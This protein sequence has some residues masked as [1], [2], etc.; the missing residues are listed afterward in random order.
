VIGNGAGG[1]TTLARAL[2][3][4]HHE[5][6]AVVFRSDWS[7]APRREVEAT[8]DGWLDEDDWV[9]DGLGPLD[10]VRRRLD[11]ADT[12]VWIDLPL[13]THLR[14]AI[15]RRVGPPRRVTVTSI[16]RMHLRY[17]PTWDEELVTHRHKLVRLRT[18]DEVRAWLED[19][20]AERRGDELDG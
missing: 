14:R 2:G 16:L 19:A 20:R 12:I 8:L 1:K 9:I 11:R 10:C 4:P 13:R 5:V 15:R 6:D 3:L 17:L 7:R 18:P